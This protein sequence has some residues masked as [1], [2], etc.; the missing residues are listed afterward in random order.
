[1]GGAVAGGDCRGVAQ[2]RG[3]FAGVRAP[4]PLS[5]ENN[6]DANGLRL[7]R[8]LEAKLTHVRTILLI[9]RVAVVHL[10]GPQNP[11]E[12]HFYFAEGCHLYIAVTVRVA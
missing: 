11:G 10:S 2:R 12:C 8:R 5:I 4:R 7:H 9:Y 1:V 3:S 6:C